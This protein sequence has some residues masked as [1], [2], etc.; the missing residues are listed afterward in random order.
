MAQNCKAGACRIE[1]LVAIDDR[2]QMV[3]PKETRDR[4]RIEAGEKLALVTWEKEGKVCCIT[5]IPASEL[6]MGIQTFIS[7]VITE[8]TAQPPQKEEKK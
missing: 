1:A 8:A 6:A 4:M 5:L 2:G 3:I 7:S